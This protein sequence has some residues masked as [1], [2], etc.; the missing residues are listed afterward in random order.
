MDGNKLPQDIEIAKKFVIQGYPLL[1]A[2]SMRSFNMW[3]VGDR[4]VYSIAA[5][6]V[7]AKVTRDRLMVDLDAKYPQYNFAQVM[8]AH[9]FLVLAAGEL[10]DL[11]QHKGY[12]TWEHRSLLMTHGPCEVHRR[13]YG[14]VKRA[15]EAR[16]VAQAKSAGKEEGKSAEKEKSGPRT[17]KRKV[18]ATDR[19]DVTAQSRKK[20]KQQAADA[21][22]EVE[23]GVRRSARSGRRAGAAE[24]VVQPLMSTEKK[25]TSRKGK[26]GAVE[27]VEKKVDEDG[28]PRRRSP[29][30]QQTK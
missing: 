20:G 3:I 18:A 28:L 7:I 25:A 16:E 23:S 9:C 19:E 22:V 5:A 30:L 2:H 15:L 24:E 6:S 26:K 1:S 14:P 4:H 21:G 10:T 8:I 27:E 11:T 17:G 12:P 29:R 13:S